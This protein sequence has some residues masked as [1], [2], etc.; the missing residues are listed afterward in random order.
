MLFRSDIDDLVW[1][2]HATRT[3][4]ASE[5]IG[6]SGMTPNEAR[7]HYFALPPIAGGDSAYM[8]QQNFSLEALAKRDRDDPFSK[9]P[10]APS[11]IT[12]PP[13]SGI[14]DDLEAAAARLLAKDW[15]ALY[16]S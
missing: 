12:G 10:D 16:A 3:K 8:Q 7:R 2:D 4:S 13:P 1:M 5:A 15:T 9:A 14:D 11:A 6:G